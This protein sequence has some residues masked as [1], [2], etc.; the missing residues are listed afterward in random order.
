MYVAHSITLWKLKCLLLPR[1]HNGLGLLFSRSISYGKC[2]FYKA[3]FHCLFY[4]YSE[5]VYGD[6]QNGRCM[7]WCRC[8]FVT[9][10]CVN[11]Q[12]D[13]LSCLVYYKV[14]GFCQ[15]ICTIFHRTL[16]PLLDQG[17]KNSR[18]KTLKI[19]LTFWQHFL[20]DIKTF[21]LL[22]GMPLSLDEKKP[23]KMGHSTEQTLTPSTTKITSVE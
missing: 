15:Q 1:R 13:K 5:R 19:L 16:K 18:C 9:R 20:D 7:F 3:I 11:G 2:V 12:K 22:A 4:V 23:N 14:H 8:E 17:N 6:G 10:W 21:L